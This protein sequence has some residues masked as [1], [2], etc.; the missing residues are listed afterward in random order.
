METELYEDED[1]V[2][3]E[4]RVWIRVDNVSILIRNEKDTISIYAFPVNEE[5][6][7]PLDSIYISKEV[8]SE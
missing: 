6:G 3:K 2:L 8:K 4:K 5:S 7:E 1:Y